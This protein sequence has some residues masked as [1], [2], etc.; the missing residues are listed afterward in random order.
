MKT[1][2]R[3]RTFSESHYVRFQGD[4]NIIV[5]EAELVAIITNQGMAWLT[6]CNTPILNRPDA[7]KYATKLNELIK[8]NRIRLATE[9]NKYK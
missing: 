6:L 9:R 5:G 1:H 3:Y 2:R 7:I 8:F 4:D